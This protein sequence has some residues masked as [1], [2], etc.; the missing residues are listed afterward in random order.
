MRC[1]SRQRRICLARCD[2]DNLSVGADKTLSRGRGICFARLRPHG[3]SRGLERE[4]G[5]R[6]RQLLPVCLARCAGV[7]RRPDSRSSWVDQYPQDHWA[8]SMVTL[9][10]RG[11]T[12]RRSTTTEVVGRTGFEVDIP[13]SA[14]CNLEGL[15]RRVPQRVICAATDRAT[16][17]ERV[18]V[19][20][21]TPS[22][23]A[24]PV[25]Q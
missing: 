20:G 9:A 15:P 17:T 18:A 5:G 12:W 10:T 11:P 14:P 22:G 3:A 7:D 4:E 16:V 25:P 19:A 23:R 2:D 24:K 21:G 13:S 1:A 8:A 6:R